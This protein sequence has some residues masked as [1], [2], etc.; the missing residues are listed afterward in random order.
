MATDK[1]WNLK[2]NA[3]VTK[4]FQ[5]VFKYKVDVQTVETLV[6]LSS[7]VDGG[8]TYKIR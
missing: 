6:V 1:I 4:K 2:R 3:L 8:S 7:S 5:Y